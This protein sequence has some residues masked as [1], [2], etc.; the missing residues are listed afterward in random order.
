VSKAATQIESLD[1]SMRIVVLHGR[2]VFLVDEA[3][4]ILVERLA[5]SHGSE[6]ARFRLDGEAV[7]LAD[8]LDE[9]RSGALFEPH[10]LVIVDAADKF[11]SGDQRRRAMEA[12]AANPSSEATLLFRAQKW[13]PGKFDKLVNKVGV[14]IKCEPPSERDAAS[15]CVGA[16]AARHEVKVE[17]PAAQL[18]VERLGPDLARLDME[19]AKLAAFVG[20][21]KPISKKSV[22]ELVGHSRE[23]QAWALQTAIMSGSPE[24]A[25]AKLREL[26]D[27]SRLDGVVVMWAIAD[28]LR[29]MHAA[30]RLIRQGVREAAFVRPMRL[31]WAPGDRILEAARRADPE[32]IA[33]LLHETVSADHRWRS[34]RGDQRRNLE[35]V[36]L[37]VTDTISCF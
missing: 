9:L 32:R 30:S 24:E 8:V 14:V 21:G 5:E 28:L 31:A 1:A 20:I 15:W 11:I 25:A 19:I 12:Y 17:R 13:Y 37:L 6:V 34:G 36:T 29:K 27:V 23:E 33:Q 18:L 7:G 16:G 22:Q 10:K 35:A 26:L 3:T 4:R 2:E